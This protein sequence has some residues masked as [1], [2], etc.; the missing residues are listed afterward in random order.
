M[1]NSLLL[2]TLIFLAVVFTIPSVTAQVYDPITFDP[3]GSSY[4]WI[5]FDNDPGTF[6]IVANPDASGINTSATVGKYVT[7]AAAPLWAGVKTDDLDPVIITEENKFLTMDV[8]KT[9]TEAKV[10]LKYEGGT[11]GNQKDAFV[12]N[13][14]ADVWETL[15]FDFSAVVGD[16]FPTLVIFPDWPLD[17][18]R[19]AEATTYFDNIEWHGDELFNPELNPVTFDPEGSGYNWI[20]FDNDP[21]TFE[22]VANPDASGINTSA[23]VGKYVTEAA[24]PLWA[25]VK[26]DDLDPVIITE[27]NKFLTMDVYKTDTEAKVGLKYEGG[28]G[29]NQKDAFVENTQADVWETL[30][31][32][33]SAV[34]GDTFPTL[35]IFPDWP[36]DDTRE[37]EATTYFDNIEWHAENPDTSTAVYAPSMNE[38]TNIYP[39]PVVDIL[40]INVSEKAT[41]EVFNLTGSVM[42]TVQVPGRTDYELPFGDMVKGI[43][44]INVTSAGITKVFKIIKQ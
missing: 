16:T 13:T 8:Y 12:E 43:Y 15:V 4:T 9:D 6:E 25:G 40:H 39:N 31:F 36:L 3:E 18:T 29:G 26:T 19:E 11:G 42:K 37:A 1:K 44:L 30:V 28:T 34:V 38:I 41:I 14:Q 21:G 24:A 17:G 5:K 32:D 22:I 33:F 7:E 27:E 20:K 23:T 2:K 10:G 35:V